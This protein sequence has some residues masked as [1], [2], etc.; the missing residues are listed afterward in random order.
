MKNC[1]QKKEEEEGSG[2]QIGTTGVGLSNKFPQ[3]RR[4][5]TVDRELLII[6]HR[7]MIFI[8]DTAA[9]CLDRQPLLYVWWLSDW[10]TGRGID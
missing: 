9:D 8:A 6:Q 7:Y 10:C 1:G 2:K 4:K 3:R 5:V